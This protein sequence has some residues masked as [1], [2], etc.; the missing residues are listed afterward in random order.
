M[1]VHVSTARAV[2][3]TIRAASVEL[4]RALK[5][6]NAR[7]A[8][9]RLWELR[10]TLTTLAKVR[11]SFEVETEELE[12]RVSEPIGFRVDDDSE[13]D[14]GLDVEQEHESDAPA[15]RRG[16]RP[17]PNLLQRSTRRSR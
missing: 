8:A 14:Q 2:E 16:V 9:A 11:G 5:N 4:T 12:P 1:A 13:P 7:G 6:P 10:Q 15:A 17:W 3:R